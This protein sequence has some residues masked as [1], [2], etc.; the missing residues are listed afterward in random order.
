[1]PLSREEV[2]HI[3]SLCRI[4]MTDEEIERMGQQLSHILGQFQ[5]LRQV[6]TEDVPP[7]SHAVA[8]ESI[9]RNDEVQPSAEMED[10]LANAPRRQ[11]DLFRVNTVVEE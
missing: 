3:A 8:L 4:A 1:M 7:T 10:V 5:V 11:G 9:Y 2:V 6:K